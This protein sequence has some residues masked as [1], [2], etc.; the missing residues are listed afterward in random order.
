MNSGR[1]R[2]ELECAASGIA[3]P[4]KDCTAVRKVHGEAVLR[5]C[6][7]ALRSQPAVAQPAEYVPVNSTRVRRASD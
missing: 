7:A 6:P 4:T 2:N 3:V 5:L 1:R